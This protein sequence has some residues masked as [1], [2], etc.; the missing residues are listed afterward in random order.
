MGVVVFPGH[1][2][3]ALEALAKAKTAV[4]EIGPDARIFIFVRDPKK[5]ATRSLSS[6]FNTIDLAVVTAYVNA[7]CS[8]HM[9]RA[10]GE[11]GDD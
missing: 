4:D 8:D 11:D 1:E 6:E 7:Y 3:S 2:G 5:Q 9:M 10:Q